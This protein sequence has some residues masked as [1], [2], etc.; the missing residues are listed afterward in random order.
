MEK[1]EGR[2]VLQP[3]MIN[4]KEG[5]ATKDVT[6]RVKGLEIPDEKLG[7]SWD[8]NP[9]P[10]AF[11]ADALTTELLKPHGSGAADKLYMYVAT[12]QQLSIGISHQSQL[13]STPSP[14]T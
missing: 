8:L 1:K 14:L 5:L 4:F 12:L 3:Y 7:T 13:F 2:G 11:Q 6:Y 9:V 10:S